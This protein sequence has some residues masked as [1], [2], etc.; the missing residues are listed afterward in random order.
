MSICLFV[1]VV[2]GGGGGGVCVR[3]C[4]RAFV[5]VCVCVCVFVYIYSSSNTCLDSTMSVSP[6]SAQRAF[7]SFA[8]VEDPVSTFP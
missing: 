6:S 4:V 8:H 7:R 1:V 5:C 3:A 2:V